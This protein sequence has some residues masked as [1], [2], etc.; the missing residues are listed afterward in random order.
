[1]HAVGQV[2]GVPGFDD[3]AGVGFDG[4]QVAGEPDGVVA[5][6]GAGGVGEPASGGRVSRRGAAASAG[7]AT[8]PRPFRVAGGVEIVVVVMGGYQGMAG[9][10]VPK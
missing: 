7:A 6:A 1:M 4:V 8:D 10:P 3:P 5:A 2:G 9:K